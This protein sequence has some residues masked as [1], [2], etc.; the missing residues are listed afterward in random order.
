MLQTIRDKTTGT[1]AIFVVAIICVPFA[2]FGIEQFASGGSDPA[3]A[4]VDGQKITQRQ[5]SNGYDQAYQRFQQLLGDN[6]DPALVQSPQFKQSVLQGLIQDEVMSQHINDAGYRVGEA[7]A[8]ETIRSQ[9][10]AA[11]PARRAATSSA[12]VARR[13]ASTRAL[14][15]TK[16]ARQRSPSRT[17]CMRAGSTRASR[18]A[19][20]GFSPDRRPFDRATSRTVL[21]RCAMRLAVACFSVQIG[22]RHINTSG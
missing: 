22:A 10:A 14:A 8:F 20:T 4:K 21:M 6:F 13:R 18:I 3:V 12:A 15:S 1:A 5:Y 9:S 19:A 11:L 2:F 16:D 7:R 17:T